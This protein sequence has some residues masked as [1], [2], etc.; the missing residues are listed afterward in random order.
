MRL[1]GWTERPP[2]DS[3][4]PVLEFLTLLRCLSRSLWADLACPRKTGFP[5]RAMKCTCRS[6]CELVVNKLRRRAGVLRHPS[7]TAR[8]AISQQ[9][10]MSLLLLP[11]LLAPLAVQ[12]LPSVLVYTR[13]AGEPPLSS[14]NSPLPRAKASPPWTNRL[15]TRLDPHCHPSPLESVDTQWRTV[16]VQLYVQ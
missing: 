8:P 13:T 10:A 4:D 9:Q 12:A 11:L 15:P 7:S 2:G 3:H 5:A 16:W 14:S 6:S 1:G